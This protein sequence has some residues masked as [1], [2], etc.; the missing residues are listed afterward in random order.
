MN[1]TALFTA[2]MG[3]VLGTEVGEAA[4]VKVINM[5]E[6]QVTVSIDGQYGCTAEAKTTCTFTTTPGA[7]RLSAAAAG[8]L[9]Y[10]QDVVVPT[11]DTYEFKI[12]WKQ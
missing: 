5:I 7:H 3:I 11:N 10:V 6:V 12:Q 8:A 9:P 1:W 4:A 2:L